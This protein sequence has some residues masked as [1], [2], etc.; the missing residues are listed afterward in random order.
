MNK[1]F[2]IFIILAFAALILLLVFLNIGSIQKDVISESNSVSFNPLS[3]YACYGCDCIFTL[4]NGKEY[5]L[6]EFDKGKCLNYQLDNSG[7]EKEIVNLNDKEY[8]DFVKCVENFSNNPTN[9]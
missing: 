7:K 1:K 9:P 3:C 6:N 4:A 5:K 2:L 8:N